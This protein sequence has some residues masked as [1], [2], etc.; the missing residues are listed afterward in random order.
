MPKLSFCFGFSPRW[1]RIATRVSSIATFVSDG[2]VGLTVSWS[3]C[4]AAEEVAQRADRDDRVLVLVVA[5]ERALLLRDAHDAE[6]DAADADFLVDRV[7]LL[8]EPI[9]DV[10]AEEYHRA[11]C[12]RSPAG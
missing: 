1:T 3:D 4:R 7:D 2:V 9:R 6:V 11:G 10:P 5:E 12:G 8:E